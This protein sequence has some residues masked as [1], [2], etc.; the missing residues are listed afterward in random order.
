MPPE[1]L[2]GESVDA[3]ADIYSIGTI[4]Y[5]MGTDRRAFPQEL[6]S[7]VI[8]A[9]LHHSPVTPRALN[10]RISPELERIVL[11]C[12]DKDPGQRFQ[13]AK[14]LLVDL[15]RLDA[16]M[17]HRPAFPQPPPLK[18]KGVRWVVVYSLV[19]LLAI[20]VTLIAVNLHGWRDHLMGRPRAANI[21]S[22]AVLPFV[23]FSGDADQDYFADGMTDA[24][25]NDLGQIGALRVIS[26]TSVMSYKGV[27]RSLPDI[28]RQLHV[29]AVVE[30]SVRRNENR[31]QINVQLVQASTDLQ[32]WGRSYEEDPRDILTLQNTAARA[33]ADEI[34]IKLTPQEQAR[35]ASTREVNPAAHEAYLKGNYLKLGTQEQRERS[36]QYL[37]EAIRIDPNYAPAYAGLA[38][39]YWSA[40]ELH[41]RA[42]MPEAEKYALKALELDPNLAHAHLALGA[43]R[44]YGDW[45]WEGADRE[46]KRAIELNPGD[47]EAHRTYAFYL[48]ALS[49][50]GE[51]DSEI[52]RAEDLDP[53]YIATQVTAGWVF[54]FARRYD[55]A[56]E[57]CQRALE[58]DPNSAGG[59][60][61]LGSAY[62]AKGMHE[63]AIAACRQAVILSANAP[64]R[65]VGLGQAYA[66][67]GKNPEARE[68]LKGLRR[69]A[70]HG[71]LPPFFLAKLSVALGEHEQ[72]L[73]WLE[74]SYAERDPYLAWL[75]I[76]RGFD[77]L[78]KDPRFQDLLRRVGFSP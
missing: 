53:L 33:I 56:I 48:S 47:S 71:Y 5:E 59:Y 50:E 31:V 76:E 17:S 42:A 54:Y 72:A 22:L 49:R 4:L 62:L 58:L 75:K 70:T 57:Q 2:Q 61:C 35:L 38:D 74:E 69:E 26:R 27:K 77:P 25:I 8:D 11:K 65:A 12:L 14:E 55:Q 52:R 44:F 60:D 19:A 24:L 28:A 39:H 41:P 18:P 9:I 68:V 45:D 10:S 40:Q 15:R 51:A 7:R 73:T 6:P 23:N 32:L 13:S 67:A 3:R 64:A 29:D 20:P 21:R 36:K 63:Q 30:G 66:L 16:S 34:Q 78:R 1:Q 43:I 46:F 37:E